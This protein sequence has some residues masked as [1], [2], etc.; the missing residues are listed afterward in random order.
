MTKQ[1]TPN[2]KTPRLKITKK[3]NI[4][5]DDELFSFYFINLLSNWI[6]N[7]LSTVQPSVLIKIL[8]IKQTFFIRKEE[9]LFH[10]YEVC[11]FQL[12]RNSHC[13]D[14]THSVEHWDCIFIN[15]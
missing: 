15:S 14:T 12:Y 3:G 1:S 7:T 9:K 5:Q 4:I 2:R 10:S 8:S 11:P 13:Q 6:P